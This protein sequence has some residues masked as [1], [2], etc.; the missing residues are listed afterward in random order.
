[1]LLRDCTSTISPY[2]FGVVDVDYKGVERSAAER[3]VVVHDI[4]LL[5]LFTAAAACRL[6]QQKIQDLKLKAA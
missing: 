3:L 4:E 5:A 6:H 2:K 1:M